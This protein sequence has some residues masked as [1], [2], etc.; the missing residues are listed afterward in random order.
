MKLYKRVNRLAYLKLVPK[1]IQKRIRWALSLKPGDLIN[2]CSAFN[3]I[4]RTIEPDIWVSW[5]NGWFIYDINF[6]TEP[7]GGTCS[8]R[9]CGV[10]KPLTPAQ[11]EERLRIFYNNWGEPHGGWRFKTEQD[12]VWERL[13]KGLPICDERGI[14]LGGNS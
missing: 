7:F 14:K 6:T 5:R 1:R 3:V 10:T 9:K 11:I 13:S 2:D 4:I 12:I 8:L